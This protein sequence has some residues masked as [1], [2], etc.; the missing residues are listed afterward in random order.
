MPN[1]AV[2]KPLRSRSLPAWLVKP[3]KR[4][5]LL[6]KMLWPREYQHFLTFLNWSKGFPES[7]ISRRS[8]SNLLW[9]YKHKHF[10]T[11]IVRIFRRVG[12]TL[13]SRPIISTGDSRQQ[14][15]PIN[16]YHARTISKLLTN[17]KT[18]NTC[19]FTYHINT[20]NTNSTQARRDLRVAEG[21]VAVVVDHG[22]AAIGVGVTSE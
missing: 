5:L 18:K 12:E 17:I 1:R 21:V 7:S 14:E 3:L 10:C 15:N 13:D 16:F 8:A 20:S 2:N 9:S 22:W 11:N 6:Y 19:T 4:H